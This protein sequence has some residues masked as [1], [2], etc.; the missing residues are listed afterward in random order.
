MTV[1]SVSAGGRQVVRA[2]R[3]LSILADQLEDGVPLEPHPLNRQD[4]RNVAVSRLL[5]PLGP[6]DFLISRKENVAG[7]EQGPGIQGPE[8]LVESPGTSQAV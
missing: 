2:A 6:T 4:R 7:S 5:S 3:P 1:F 8:P